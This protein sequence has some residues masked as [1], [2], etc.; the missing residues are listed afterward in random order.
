MTDH[1]PDLDHLLGR[2]FIRLGVA[3]GLALIGYLF[4]N[5]VTRPE[6]QVISANEV[7]L[8]RQQDG[9]YHISGAINDEP[10]VFMLDTGATM[11]SISTKLANRA[12]LQCAQTAAFA[13]ASGEIDG[14]IA[15]AKAVTLGNYRLFD[16]D[17]AIMPSVDGLALL[18]MNALGKFDIQ[19]TG[20][21]LT[22]T[23][24][25]AN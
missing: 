2:S 3:L 12:G 11:V 14:C 24:R 23:Q 18:G 7:R 10:V 4:Y 13:T 19:Q 22:I 21:T 25:R 20:H 9:H 16:L 6:M 5:Q 15:H 17:V 1:P 8:Q